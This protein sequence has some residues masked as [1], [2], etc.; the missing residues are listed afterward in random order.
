MMPRGEVEASKQGALSLACEWT[1]RQVQIHAG[2]MD[3]LTPSW[4]R[5]GCLRLE[6]T[7][8]DAQTWIER[9]EAIL[10]AGDQWR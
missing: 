7:A 3:V 9:D 1:V 6:R 4:A 10:Q 2:N 5:S 8:T